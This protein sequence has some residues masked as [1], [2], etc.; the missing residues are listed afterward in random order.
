L[1]GWIK[2]TPPYRNERQDFGGMPQMAFIRRYLRLWI[3]RG[4][5]RN[6]ADGEEI[7]VVE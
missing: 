2:G 3:V 7:V 5:R 1:I 6:L 4:L